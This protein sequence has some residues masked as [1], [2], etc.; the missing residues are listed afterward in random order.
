MGTTW[1]CYQ[2]YQERAGFNYGIEHH[3]ALKSI[4]NIQKHSTPPPAPLTTYCSKLMYLT[5]V[6]LE[7]STQTLQMSVEVSTKSTSVSW[8]HREKPEATVRGGDRQQM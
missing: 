5:T 3:T 7:S 8:E 1:E 6:V 4:E 2:Y